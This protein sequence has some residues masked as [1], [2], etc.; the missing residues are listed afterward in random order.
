[1]IVGVFRAWFAG[2]IVAMFSLGGAFMQS[3]AAGEENGGSA[4]RQGQSGEGIAPDSRPSAR[5][6]DFPI[7]LTDV[8]GGFVGMSGW[9]W[10]IERDG[11]WQ[12]R[13]YV[14]KPKNPADQQGRLSREQ[15]ASLAGTLAANDFAALPDIIGRTPGANPHQITLAAGNKKSMLELGAGKRLPPL[16]PTAGNRDPKNRFI[17]SVQAVLE[18]VTPRN[19][20][21]VP[22]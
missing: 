5:G 18:L 1:M 4:Q 11:S 17:S 16:D 6:L 8:Q 10:T 21:P 19:G 2:T 7:V 3:N 12:R 14:I 20:G 9:I 22:K 15:L 13:R